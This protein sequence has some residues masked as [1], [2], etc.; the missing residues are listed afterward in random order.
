MWCQLFDHQ[1]SEGL[2]NLSRE[3]LMHFNTSILIMLEGKEHTS[4]E[5]QQVRYSYMEAIKSGTSSPD[6]LKILNKWEKFSRSRLMIWCRLRIIESMKIMSRNP[7]KIGKPIRSSKEFN[8]SQDVC[9]DL[10]SWITL[11]QVSKFEICLNISYM[12]VLHNKEKSEEK[13]GFLKIFSK[14]IKEEMAMR[15]ADKRFF[16]S[17]EPSEDLKSHEFSP[18]FCCAM[19]DSIKFEL[20]KK[21]GSIENWFDETVSRKLLTRNL[22][23]LSTTKK[24]AVGDLKRE[25]HVYNQKDNKRQ[26]CLESCL[27]L[28]KNGEDFCC[29]KNIGKYCNEVEEEYGGIVANLFKKLQIGGVREIFVLE[30]RCRIV[31]HFLETIS[32]VAGEVI[33]MEMLTKGDKKLQRTDAHFYKLA[34]LSG[35][36]SVSTTLINS[37]D[38]TTWAQRFIMPVFGCVLSRVL[39][40]RFLEPVM[41]ILNLVTNKKLELPSVLLDMF[42][43]NRDI[44]GFD[45]Q[46]N[47]LKDQYL[48]Q[49]INNDL[50]DPRKRFLKNKSNMMQGILHYTSSLV[51]CGYLLL[52]E[53]FT[54]AR[55]YKSVGQKFKI[56]LQITSK[57]S[58]DDSSVILSAVV[59]RDC[60]D[61]LQI[62]KRHL[63]GCLNSKSQAYKYFS[64]KQSYEKST[65]S[66]ETGV[67]EFNSLWYYRNTLLS[68]TIKFVFAAVRTHPSS[69]ISERFNV[70]SNLRSNVLEHSGSAMLCSLIQYCQAMSHYRVL[71][72]NSNTLWK[73]FETSLIKQ[74]HP[75]F[76]FFLFEPSISTGILGQDFSLYLACKNNE[77]FRKTHLS[78]YKSNLLEFSPDGKPTTRTY[79]SFGQGELFNKF[80][81]RNN[82]SP[83]IIRNSLKENI[84]SLYDKPK[85]NESALLKLQSIAINPGLSESMSFLTDSKLHSASV[86]F[87]QEPVILLS[88]GIVSSELRKC[89]ML[90]LI[91][92]FTSNNEQED[93]KWLFPYSNFYEDSIKIMGEFK[94]SF[95]GSSINR[96][97]TFNKIYVKTNKLDQG[98][99][100]LE[101]VRRKWFRIPD[102]RGSNMMHELTWT[103]YCKEFSWLREGIE[104]TLIESPFLDHLSL[105]NFLMSQS[106]KEKTVRVYGPSSS[107]TSPLDVLRGVIENCQW[108]GRRLISESDMFIK[109]EKFPMKDMLDKIWR[110]ADCPPR[111]DKK[112]VLEEYI[113]KLP[114]VNKY[115]DLM[116]DLHSLGKTELSMAIL[117]C[118]SSCKSNDGDMSSLKYMLNR[119]NLG[120]LGK[121]EKRQKYMR[122]GGYSGEGIFRGTFDG[123]KAEIHL[124][125]NKAS[126][127]KVEKIESLSICSETILEFIKSIG[128]VCESSNANAKFYSLSHKRVYDYWTKNSVPYIETKLN[129][130]SNMPMTI[131]DYHAEIT[132]YGVIRIVYK[133]DDRCMTIF[134]HR[135][136][137]RDNKLN[138]SNVTTSNFFIDYWINSYPAPL[139]MAKSEVLNEANYAWACET[140]RSRLQG[141]S[142][143]PEATIR[144]CEK[145]DTESSDSDLSE[146]LSMAFMTDIDE[147]EMNEMKAMF[148]FAEDAE[149]SDSEGDP[150]DFDFLMSTDVDGVDF[151][152]FYQPYVES[153]KDPSSSTNKSLD[154][155]LDWLTRCFSRSVL[156][157]RLSQ[158]VLPIRKMIKDAEKIESV[159]EETCLNDDLGF[160]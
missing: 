100:L 105:Y 120:I 77:L 102:V 131:T 110:I 80:K 53:K 1:L 30:F 48:G 160:F 5:L 115:I 49:S 65:T 19:G 124:M 72:L 78:M 13:H 10:I 114:S 45:D 90:S 155:L 83:D 104:E 50:V 27:E 41:C 101:V 136:S 47:E 141:R 97:S 137:S 54:K 24:T 42:D 111:Y 69:R 88:S 8:S 99:S 89:S 122:N 150:E 17:D 157:H 23:K 51:H 38:A 159:L 149:Y 93:F 18:E 98:V 31:T 118:Y 154:S 156:I 108:K 82:L 123:I 81:S 55:I 66:V 139:E 6:L 103:S 21:I 86:F 37:D 43:D 28:L 20:E 26:T 125:D 15:E 4:K 61:K 145:A 62:I 127:L 59:P 33:D 128:C 117:L 58:S 25:E 129:W 91:R 147:T 143:I 109:K 153:M 134:S 158:D 113:S 12:G 75:A 146:K 76:G 79:L 39:P 132:S 133:E 22:T 95:L 144:H 57:V 56:N 112:R 11:D 2:E 116:M 68:P 142:L 70:F 94:K 60:S 29:M 46:L 106:A 140:I 126:L 36:G 92:E 138:L 32:R 35:S 135:I 74:P 67:E 63:E 3:I 152:V 9:E 121:F 84:M 96:R 7:P 87:I 148:G 52:W 85:D 130:L 16:G 73:E 34:Q 119:Y 151:Q 71:G 14:V 40:P 107:A 64:A 44:T